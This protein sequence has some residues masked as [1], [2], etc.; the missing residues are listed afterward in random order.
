MPAIDKN[1]AKKGVMVDSGKGHEPAVLRYLWRLV[2]Q[3]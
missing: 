2:E 1:K 3:E